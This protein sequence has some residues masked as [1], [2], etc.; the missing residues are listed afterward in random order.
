MNPE[1]NKIF[2]EAEERRVKTK[3]DLILESLRQTK[4]VNTKK[5][6]TDVEIF[7]A[8]RKSSL[9]LMLMPMWA[10]TYAPYNL[11]RLSAVTK[12]A[13]YDT[14]VFDV[15]VHGYKISREWDLGWDPYHYVYMT[16]W[17]KPTYQEIL[18]P[19]LIPLFQEYVDK[20][21]EMNPTAVGFTLY[22]QNKEPVKWMN[23]ELKKR[24]PNLITILGGPICHR[25]NPMVGDDEFGGGNIPF[26]YIAMGEGEELILDILQDIEDNGKPE[27]MKHFVQD[28]N[29]KLN[30]DAMPLPDYSHFDFNDYE[31]PNGATTEL[32]RGCTA[33]CVFCDETHF[34]KYRNRESSKVMDEMRYLYDR[35]VNSI[36]FLDSLVNGNI[37]ELNNFMEQMIESDMRIQWAGYMRCDE[38]MDADF[39]KKL[40]A[41][42]CYN[43]CYGVESGSNKVLRDM[44]KGITREEIESNFKNASAV[45]IEGVMMMIPG[46]PTETP[47]EFYETFIT[48]WRIRNCKINYIAAGQIGLAISEESIIGHMRED[49]GVLLHSFGHNWITRDFENSKVH[50]LIRMKIFNIFLNNLINDNNT[51][52]S[53]RKSIEKT[54]SLVFKDPTLQNEL[55]YEEDFDFNIIKPN[56]DNNLANTV[57]NEIWPLLRLM[58]RARGAFKFECTFDAEEDSKEFSIY[59]GC[60]FDA[61]YYFEI[62][63]E[64]NWKADFKMSFKQPEEYWHHNSF[65]HSDSNAHKRIQTWSRKSK[66]PVK[67]LEEGYQDLVDNYLDTDL[68]FDYHYVDQGKW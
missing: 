44:N 46:F 23:R 25:T 21:V 61:K 6:Q 34:W 10:P 26:E 31:M 59:L 39:Y 35:G 20:I 12:A 60:P 41:S 66:F 11:A 14:H 5:N 1:Q 49:Y 7:H 2:E 15:N 19:H 57:V 48:L 58:Y 50:R 43:I 17:F 32:S 65:A 29:Q 8:T 68:S 47:S 53:N 42:G 4:Q 62:D 24:L 28:Y 55:E 13:G 40:K 27:S 22:D 9:V 18:E 45:G 63:E 36:W 33:K 3:D 67:T 64:G 16:R 51:D 38:R 52:F 54:Y 30:L 37:R 56:T